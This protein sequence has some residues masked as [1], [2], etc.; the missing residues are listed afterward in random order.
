M[1]I[2]R[3]AGR[4]WVFPKPALKRCEA[5]GF[6]LSLG[7]AIK[8]VSSDSPDERDVRGMDRPAALLYGR[9]VRQAGLELPLCCRSPTGHDHTETHTRAGTRR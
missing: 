1:L 8:G 9:G 3:L 6:L 4:G 5:G 2:T 7:M